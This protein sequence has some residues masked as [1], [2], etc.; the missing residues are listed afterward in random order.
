M[1]FA[2]QGWDQ[3]PMFLWDS[4]WQLQSKQKLIPLQGHFLLT[5]TLKPLDLLHLQSLPMGEEEL[6]EDLTEPQVTD[7]EGEE[8]EEDM[9]PE[10]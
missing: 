6:E 9:Q 4:S 10:Q 2:R 5:L 8:L 3:E 1:E 7:R